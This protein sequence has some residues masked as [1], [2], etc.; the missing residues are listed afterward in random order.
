M[1][2]PL[3]KFKKSHLS[4]SAINAFRA[5]PVAEL[6]RRFEGIKDAD[7]MNMVRGR[8]AEQV[9][10]L[11]ICKKINNDQIDT[12]IDNIFRNEI[13]FKDFGEEAKEKT[14]IMLKGDGKKANG[15]VRNMYEAFN[16]LE[17]K[18]P[19]KFQ[20]DHETLLNGTLTK[21]KGKTDFEN[22]KVVIDWKATAQIR[23]TEI[24]NRVQGGIY[25]KMTG[26]KRIIFIKASKTKFEIQELTPKDIYE[27]LE[28]AVHVIKTLEH[29]CRTFDNLSDYYK[30]IYPF[31]KYDRSEVMESEIKN[32]YRKIH[33]TE[34]YNGI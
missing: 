28:T 16:Q 12:T 33:N 34:A 1:E 25:Y 20:T 11:L 2:T 19:F 14:L 6:K 22:D 8:V 29:I 31:K 5:D 3:K 18:E 15:M 13:A 26:G 10:E 27:G 17:C 4:P 32:E 21:L 9:V 23:K 7:N 24:D 30:C